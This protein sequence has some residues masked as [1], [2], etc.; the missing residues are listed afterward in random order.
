[1][2]GVRGRWE[3]GGIGVRGEVRFFRAVGR[4]KMK[5]NGGLEGGGSVCFFRFI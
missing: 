5:E 3:V 1:M 2:E 4:E